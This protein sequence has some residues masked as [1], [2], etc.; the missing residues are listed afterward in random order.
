MPTYDYKCS[1]CGHAFEAV[2]SMKDPLLTQC[3]VCG[4]ESVVRLISGG[5]VIFKGS[6]FYQT[7][8][9]GAPSTKES[10]SSAAGDTAVKPEAKPAAESTPASTPK[11]E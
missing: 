2:Q 4:K 8:Y 7:D 6:G 9:K 1:D 10:T 5:G 11:K 3:P